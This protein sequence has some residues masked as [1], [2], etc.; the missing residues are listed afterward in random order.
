MLAL[1]P[2]LFHKN[3]DSATNFYAIL[4]FWNAQMT[5]DLWPY[6]LFNLP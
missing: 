6:K 4:R 1:C 2:S 3:F 5:F